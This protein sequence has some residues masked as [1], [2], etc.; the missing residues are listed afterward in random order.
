[1]ST[2]LSRRHFLRLA[3]AVTLGFATLRQFPA[4]AAIEDA[5]GY[6]ALLPDPDGIFDLP[7]GF[8]YRVISR[9][10]GT[11][12]DGLIVPGRQDGMGAFPGPDGTTILVRNHEIEAPD[13][14]LD[15]PH[16][17]GEDGALMTDAHRPFFYDI[18]DETPSLGGTSTLI[19][20]T[21]ARELRGHHLS[22]IGTQRNCAGGPTPW[23]SWISCEEHF[24]QS[25]RGTRHGYNFEVP[26]S[27][28]GGL[29]AP[30]ALVEMGR[31]RHEA[32]AVHPRTCIVYQTEDRDDGLIYRFVPNVAGELA[33][34]G[35]LQM[36]AIA[37]RPAL[38]T[39]NWETQQV[40]SGQS[41][42]VEWLDCADP[43]PSADILRASGR[44]AGAAIF[45]RGEGMWFGTRGG[46]DA[47]YF[48]ATSGGAARKGQIW[49]LLPDRNILQLW[50]EPNDGHIIENADNLTVAPWGDVVVCEDLVKP[51]VEPLQALLGLTPKG[52]VYRLGRNVLNDSELAGVCFSP[53]ASTLF[54]NIYQPGLTLAITGPWR[55][56]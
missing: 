15:S 25:A 11:M 21:R 37:G 32:I 47:I 12:N 22:L 10:G 14:K 41:L 38:D 9:A 36:L 53:D 7:R 17:F 46:T 30:V 51:E 2:S 40:R 52:E 48:A 19:Y 16:P 44:D 8:S 27:S 39:R 4:L 5:K 56:A 1:M 20:D 18:D 31:F 33:R 34:G 49:R 28:D 43:D 3:G 23:N 50:V 45:A 54:V 6:G 29:V 24:A 26:A 13:T 35:Q 42:P 55:K